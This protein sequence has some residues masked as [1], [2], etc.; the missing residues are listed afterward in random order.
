MVYTIMTRTECGGEEVPLTRVQLEDLIR[1]HFADWCQQVS[2]C[3]HG[4]GSKLVCRNYHRVT[5]RHPLLPH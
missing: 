1:V 5:P 3:A 2:S 4:M